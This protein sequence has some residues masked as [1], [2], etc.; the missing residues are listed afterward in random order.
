MSTK[1]QL[2]NINETVYEKLSIDN[3]LY[4]YPTRG[5]TIGYYQN[6]KSYS[7]R[8]RTLRA[9]HN[10][11]YAMNILSSANEYSPKYV[12]Q[13][14]QE[15]KRALEIMLDNIKAMDPDLLKLTY[16]FL[17]N[18]TNKDFINNAVHECPMLNRMSTSKE[19]VHYLTTLLYKNCQIFAEADP[20]LKLAKLYKES[21]SYYYDDLPIRNEFF[22]ALMNDY[23]VSNELI[24]EWKK[25]FE[26]DANT[27]LLD[28]LKKIKNIGISRFGSEAFFS[29]LKDS[30]GREISTL[31]P[32]FIS[33]KKLNT[34][35]KIKIGWESIK[36]RVMKQKSKNK[37]NFSHLNIISTQRLLKL[38]EQKK[39]LDI[40][41]VLEHKDP[42]HRTKDVLLALWGEFKKEKNI[43]KDLDFN[44]DYQD[45]FKWVDSNEKNLNIPRVTY[46]N[47]EQQTLYKANLENNTVKIF[48]GPADTS[49]TQGDK[50]GFAA[51]VM[52]EDQNIYIA[53]KERNEFQHSSFLSGSDVS[54]AGLLK[55]KHGKVIAISNESGH[56]KPDDLDL[57]IAI[58]VLRNK[59]VLAPNF[60]IVQSYFPFK[61]YGDAVIDTPGLYWL[62]RAL[63]GYK[64][65][66][67]VDPDTFVRNVFNKY[68][69]LK[70][71]DTYS[72]AISYLDKPPKVDE[73]QSETPN[74][75]LKTGRKPR[76]R[77]PNMRL[78]LKAKSSKSPSENV[79]NSIKKTI[80]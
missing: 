70:G 22:E 27:I 43:S 5:T 46:L 53:E 7:P 21:E 37:P 57:A 71:T 18:P 54:C 11:F 12:L 50:A 13:S 34:V 68:A 19:E 44:S 48:G 24:E 31:N 30:R 63:K 78:L 79:R 8:K 73:S 59:N 38:R 40:L 29:A 66:Q 32:V 61:T 20:A 14:I 72:Q 45:F 3:P 9:T 16:E 1:E 74:E 28:I 55:I 67:T 15:F 33:R 49:T 4:R 36:S 62:A 77:W 52:D 76:I 23:G 60:V 47:P 56:Y 2:N 41:Y 17:D 69:Q 65:K 26:T 42:M 64:R 58:T 25:G 80:G 10:L 51:F 75:A 35:K 6:E 39:K